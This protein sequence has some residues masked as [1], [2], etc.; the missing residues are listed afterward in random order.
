M[1]G[2]KYQEPKLGADG[3]P[4]KMEKREPLLEGKT[5]AKQ[6]LWVKPRRKS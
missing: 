5:T 4:M 2:L 1:E 6:T 3:Q